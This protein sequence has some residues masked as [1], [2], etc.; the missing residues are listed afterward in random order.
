[1]FAEKDVGE[2]PCAKPDRNPAQQIWFGLGC[3]TGAV[4]VYCQKT[5]GQGA[6][7]RRTTL[8]AGTAKQQAPPHPISSRMTPRWRFAGNPLPHAVRRRFPKPLPDWSPTCFPLPA[9]RGPCRKSACPDRP[10]GR[11]LPNTP[12]RRGKYGPKENCCRSTAI[13]PFLSLIH[14]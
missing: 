7:L 11:I 4:A 5:R 12:R 14:I 9:R 1:M 3:G 2:K 6:S 10:C 13:F 8:L